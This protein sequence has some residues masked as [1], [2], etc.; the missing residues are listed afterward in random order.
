MTWAYKFMV[1]PICECPSVSI[2][3][4]GETPCASSCEAQAWRKSWNHWRGRPAAAMCSWK[5]WVTF[6]PSSG[7]PMVLVK[8]SP[9]SCHREPASNRPPSW[10]VRCARS[11]ATANAGSAI[12]RRL[13]AVLGSIRARRGPSPRYAAAARYL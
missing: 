7:V 10:R 1:M 9:C 5:R 12:V 6:G 4:R 3:T 11:A 13:R 8:T 2:T